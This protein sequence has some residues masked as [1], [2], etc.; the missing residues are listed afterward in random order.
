MI[1]RRTMLAGALIAATHAHAQSAPIDSAAREDGQ[2]DAPRDSAGGFS[3]RTPVTLL[4]DEAAAAF[5]KQ[6]E[7]ELASKD[8]RLALVFRTGRAR[9][10]LPRGI[11]YTHGAFWAYV[12][13]Q[14]AD[15]RTIRGYAVYNLYHGD[16]ESL[17]RD[18]SYLYQDYPFDFVRGSAVDDVG[19]IIP[20]REMQRRILGVMLSPLYGQLHVTHYSLISNPLDPRYQN[21]NEFM[22]DVIAA[23]AWETSDYAQIKANLR[24]HFRPTRVNVGLFARVLG[25]ITDERVKTDDHR[26]AIRTTTYESMAKFMGDNGLLQESFA[27]NRAVAAPG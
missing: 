26:G 5:A 14:L 6:I 20:T 7:T 12:P 15:G 8:A 22:L 24:E 10:D 3:T 17:P 19:V 13:I 21:C 9:A 2:G 1:A 11:S 25:P 27:L 23:A 4:N 16:G 18:Q